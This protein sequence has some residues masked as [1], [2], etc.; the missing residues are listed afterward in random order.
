MKNLDDLP[1]TL[2]KAN[3]AAVKFDGPSNVLN[4]RRYTDLASPLVAANFPAINAHEFGFVWD[5]TNF[6]LI[7]NDGTNKWKWQGT[8]VL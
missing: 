5:G 6:W 4:V 7:Y 3:A 8:Q 1:D 2:V